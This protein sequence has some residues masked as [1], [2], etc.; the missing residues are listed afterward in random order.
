M[1]AV[2]EFLRNTPEQERLRVNGKKAEIRRRLP[3]ELEETLSDTE[4]NVL[5]GLEQVV[6]NVEPIWEVQKQTPFYYKDPKN[7]SES[8]RRELEEEIRELGK[9]N[10]EILSPFTYVEKRNGEIA[11][12][13]YH[14][15]FADKIEQIVENI[16][17][18]QLIMPAHDH[19][20]MSQFYDRLTTL[21]EAF[22]GDKWEEADKERFKKPWVNKVEF[23]IGPFETNFDHFEIKTTV[24][25]LVGVID[26]QASRELNRLVHAAS[27]YIEGKEPSKIDLKVLF[28]TAATGIS[29]PSTKESWKAQVLP[30]DPRK[31]KEFGSRGL[32]FINLLEEH[33]NKMLYP[34]MNRVFE[35]GLLVKLTKQGL[36][37]AYR[38]WIALHEFHHPDK[39]EEGQDKRQGSLFL[40][41]HELHC[42]IAGLAMAKTLADHGVLDTD[43]FE[44]ILIVQI[45]RALNDIYSYHFSDKKFPDPYA[46]G[47]AALYNYLAEFASL[48]PLR[49]DGK[50]GLYQE[51]EVIAAVNNLVGKFNIDAQGADFEE[52]KKFFDRFKSRNSYKFAEPLLRDLFEE[53]QP[54]L[55]S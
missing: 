2:P 11:A 49:E 42:D 5:Q 30:N 35:H 20:L 34:V 43:Q 39:R 32:I 44:S 29:N 53:P 51:K 27:T 41:F 3:K 19:D 21:K 55:G 40:P 28:V 25:A 4:G 52:T 22:E 26:E 54:V 8:K 17:L 7:L 47:S 14:E 9:T 13:L 18:T 6:D 48:G 12:I 16:R 38:D 24:Q 46:E 23:V 15:K 31:A 33:F 1:P 36:F 45:A 50:L 10:S 37:E